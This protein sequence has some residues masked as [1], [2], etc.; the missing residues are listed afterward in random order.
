VEEGEALRR[1]D[2]TLHLS[3]EKLATL[4]NGNV[5]ITFHVPFE[6]AEEAWGVRR[7]Q[8]LLCRADL[9]LEEGGE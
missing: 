2:L 4:T 1:P 6:H 8:H 7:L 9:Y 5:S 3:P